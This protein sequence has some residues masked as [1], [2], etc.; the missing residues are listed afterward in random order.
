MLRMSFLDVYESDLAQQPPEVV[1]LLVALSELLNEKQVLSKELAALE[2]SIM[3]LVAGASV[4]EESNA[5]A[6][7]PHNL[8]PSVDARKNLVVNLT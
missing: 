1:K 6:I 3:M 5:A 4:A 2:G 8:V 7:V